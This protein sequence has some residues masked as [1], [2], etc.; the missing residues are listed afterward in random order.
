MRT[1]S[2]DYSNLENQIY[3]KAY[4]F[5]DVKN[6]LETVAFDIVR[7]KN[8]DKGADLWQIQKSADGDYIVAVYQE[9]DGL[10]KTS[11]LWDVS[12]NKVANTLQVSYK[13]DPIVKIAASKLNIPSNDLHNVV[14]YLPEKLANNKKLVK[15]LLNELPANTKQLV[16]NKYPELII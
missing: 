3:K 15:S 6:Q 7:F 5:E 2:I 8:N 4:K 10:E 16:L 12:I 1:F 13:G 9:D 11:S 14:S